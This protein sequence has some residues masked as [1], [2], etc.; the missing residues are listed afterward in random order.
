MVEVVE[1]AAAS[2]C[3]EWDSVCTGRLPR[4]WPELPLAAMAVGEPASRQ[5]LL[6]G[7]AL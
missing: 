2:V 6:R 5:A 7:A 1:V 3:A 4:L